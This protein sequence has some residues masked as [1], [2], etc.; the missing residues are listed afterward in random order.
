M[1]LKRFPLFGIFCR[2]PLTET[3]NWTWEMKITWRLL[4]RRVSSRKRI[5]ARRWSFNS[6]AALNLIPLQRFVNFFSWPESKI[7]ILNYKFHFLRTFL[8]MSLR[9]KFWSWFIVAARGST[10]CRCLGWIS[11]VVFIRNCSRIEIL[12]KNFID[13]QF[14]DASASWRLN[15]LIYCASSKHFRT[16]PAAKLQ[17]QLS[18]R[19][20]IFKS[21]T[22][23]VSRL[24]AKSQISNK[25][26]LDTLQSNCFLRMWLL[27]AFQCVVKQTKARNLICST[28]WMHIDRSRRGESSAPPL[29]PFARSKFLI[30][31]RR[32]TW[33]TKGN[34][35][36]INIVLW[37]E[38]P[39]W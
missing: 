21:L 1:I 39:E 4:C 20:K 31:N 2:L 16:H 29:K 32:W 35:T 11:M 34:S 6:R 18:N 25:N 33:C 5:S 9:R 13:L 30:K 27:C 14:M 24:T 28:I 15:A 22:F 10:K 19:N 36:K 26:A 38:V 7:F 17:F 12:F 8:Q 37:S 3:F 23:H